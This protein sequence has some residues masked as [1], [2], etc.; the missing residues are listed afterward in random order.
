MTHGDIPNGLTGV[1]AYLTW[2]FQDLSGHRRP[3]TGELEQPEITGA[4]RGFSTQLNSQILTDSNR[5]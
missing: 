2:L 3:A 5:F 4:T 1:E